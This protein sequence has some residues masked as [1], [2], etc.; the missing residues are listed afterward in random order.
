MGRPFEKLNCPLLFQ[1][2]KVPIVFWTPITS[3]FLNDFNKMF[4]LP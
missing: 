4:E 3:K 2:V 1:V